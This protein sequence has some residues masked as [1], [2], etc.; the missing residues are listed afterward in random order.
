MDKEIIKLVNVLRR[1][2]RAS[3]YAAWV[4]SDPDAA[5]FCAVQYNKVLA[6]LCELEPNL[7]TVFAPLPENAAPEVTRI[8]AR[9][10]ATYFEDEAPD[11]YAWRFAWGCRPGAR[12]ARS[13]CF[14][15]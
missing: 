15:A 11:P 7:R 14:S 8:A 5:R 6:R 1:I 4:K 2:A 10:L 9:D 3:G 12:R 13:R